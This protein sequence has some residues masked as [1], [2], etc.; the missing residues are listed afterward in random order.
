MFMSPFRRPGHLRRT[1][2]RLAALFVLI[3]LSVDLLFAIIVDPPLKPVPASTT[4]PTNLSATNN[5]RIFIASM[6][7]NNEITIRSHWGAAVLDLVRH[8]GAEN[9][10]VSIIESGSWDDT[11]GALRE[12]DLHLGTLEVQRGI[13]LLET[14]HKEEIER[15]PGPYEE[16][17]VWTSRGRKELR[18]IPYLAGIQNQV[19]DKLIQLADDS[20]GQKGQ[21]FKKIL[22]LNDVVFT[23]CYHLLCI[24][25]LSY[26]VLMRI[27]IFRRKTLPL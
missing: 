2:L 26:N 5:D 21:T 27:P 15:T 19:I 9:V 22:W 23:V 11:K 4:Y 16:G 12:L 3:M 24:H 10:Y 18:R 20:S 7:W 13:E 25:L 14:T 6:R 1:W 8:F 17:W